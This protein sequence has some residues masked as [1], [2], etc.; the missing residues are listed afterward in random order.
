MSSK[1]VCGVAFA[2][3]EWSSDESLLLLRVSAL[4]PVANRHSH[5]NEQL[6]TNGLLARRSRCKRSSGKWA[7]S[8][9]CKWLPR[10]DISIRF[11]LPWNSFSGSSVNA[12]F[13][14][15][16]IICKN[17]LSTNALPGTKKKEIRK[18][19]W[20]REKERGRKRKNGVWLVKIAIGACAAH[21]AAY[22]KKTN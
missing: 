13:S 14:S 4:W 21:S 10:I 9:V 16:V 5:S 20:E 7:A 6:H 3:A 17:V 11:G 22:T 8:S 18:K 1:S 12:G 19:W 15:N 2:F